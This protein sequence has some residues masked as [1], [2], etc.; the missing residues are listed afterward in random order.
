M[1]KRTVEE[2]SLVAV[3]DTIRE[4]TGT[5]D[6]LVFP[7]G[8]KSALSKLV[9]PVDYLAAVCNKAITELVNNKVVSV[10]EN[11]QQGNTNLVKVELAALLALGSSVFS[12]CNNLT[13]VYT[14]SVKTLGS[15][16]FDSCA[17]RQISMPMLETIDGWGYNFVGCRSLAKAYFP[18]LTKIVG[19][20]TFSGCQSLV[21]LVL[22]AN[23]VCTLSHTSAFADSAIAN[24]TGYIYVPKALVGS[25]KS[26]TNWSAFASQ[27]RAIEDYPDITGG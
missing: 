2:T 3:A 27:F 11:F 20:G 10:P 17:I 6:K 23:S 5:T 8:F 14:P 9:N 1:G 24:G 13:E 25:Y 12:G 16:N 4:K 22:G 7:E 18:K 19:D 26:E 21:T 15:G